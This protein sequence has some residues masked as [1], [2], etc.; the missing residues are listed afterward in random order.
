MQEQELTL[1]EI[2][3]EL[4]RRKTEGGFGQHLSISPSRENYPKH[5]EFFD[6][7]KNFKQRLFRAA[8]RIAKTTFAALEISYHLTGHYP[9]DWNGHRFA[10]ANA[11]WVCGDR[12]DTVKQILQPMLLG[13]VGNFGTGVIPKNLL[14]LG[15]IRDAK[16]TETGVGSF[17]VLHVSGG[18]STVEFKTYQSGRS[19]FE[20]TERSIWMDEEPPEDV[21]VE[22]LLRTMT[23]N[24]ILMM[25]FTP[26][27]GISGV[28]KAFSKDGQFIE[29]DVGGGKHV[30]VA[31]WD[32]APH[33][34]PEAKKALWDSI[35]PFQRD[36][37][38]KGHPSLG[39]GA[40]YPVPESDFVVPSFPIPKHWLRLYALDVGNKTGAVWLAKDPESEQ[41][42]AFDNYYKERQEPSIHVQAIA[43]R[44]K[45]IPGAIDPAA[46]GRSQI[47]G[48]QLMEMYTDLGLKL[49]PAVNAVEA[50]LYTVWELLSTDR[51][52]IHDK[53]RYL[54]EEMRNYRRDEQGRVIK[55]ADHLCDCLR[56]AVMTR[57]IAEVEK[58]L[59]SGH[60]VGLPTQGR[61][62]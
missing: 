7:G 52:K 4:Q 49:S 48:R 46:R 24:N 44:G 33:L 40:I 19:A 39:S 21:Y 50:G 25:T 26:L 45:W 23:G 43:A 32:D 6:A 10:G 61:R 17:R 15:T 30:T 56:Y 16:K 57:D 8:N 58:P 5:W 60:L 13:T 12:S 9:P 3:E 42:H 36:A 1:A 53:C 51:L 37:R 28:V 55:E 35:P 2:V 62:F 41:W 29:G 54:I 18:W 59:N 27:R 31:T 11:W 47:D 38:T 22:A 14:D 34:T 20:G